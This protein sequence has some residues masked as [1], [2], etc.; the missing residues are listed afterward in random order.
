[1][2]L[3]KNEKNGKWSVRIHTPHGRRT[4]STGETNRSEAAKVAKQAKVAEL[5]AVGRVAKLSQGVVSQ[6]VSGER[7][8]VAS[9]I[10]PWEKWMATKT[11]DRTVQNSRNYLEAWARDTGVLETYPGAITI[12]Q[13][14]DWVNGSDLKFGTRK[15]R[16]A[17]LRSFFKFASA[18]Y[19]TGNPA[20]LVEA[21]MDGLTHE[22]KETR[23]K[24]VFT[25]DELKRILNQLAADAKVARDQLEKTTAK[26]IIAECREEI[27]YCDFWRTAIML[28]RWTGLRL[29]DICQLEWESLGKPGRII[30]WTD[31][32]DRRVDLPL[33]QEI[34][35]TVGAIPLDHDVYCFP[36]QRDI[37]MDTAKRAT[38]S[39]QF[40]RLCS[41]L[42]V[43]G[44]SFHDLRHTFLTAFVNERRAT[45]MNEAQIM[46]EARKLAGHISATTTAL[47]VH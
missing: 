21:N 20:Q 14:D 35:D 41:R 46:D 29:G 28:G 34:E 42:G 45:G 5:E 31:K 9:A 11:A 38:I 8:T 3:I 23:E 44:H 4:I 2:K 19:M 6:I 22:Q 27:A 7:V 36:V 40:A 43:V 1:M 15:V 24:T 16:L 47:Y 26:L 10:E 18:V 30:V 39:T 33:R 13:I 12:N 37:I 25:D 32:R 17:V